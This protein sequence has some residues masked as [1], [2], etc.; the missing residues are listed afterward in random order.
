[1]RSIPSSSHRLESN[2]SVQKPRVV[3]NRGVRDYLE[4][5][6]KIQA[7]VLYEHNEILKV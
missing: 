3:F 4:S 2:L 6:H 7:A 5:A 1:M